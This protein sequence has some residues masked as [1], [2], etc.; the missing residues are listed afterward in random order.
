MKLKNQLLILTSG[1]V[2]LVPI[3]VL[4]C[5]TKNNKTNSKTPIDNNKE[6][7]LDETKNS[8]ENTK[9]ITNNE[10]ETSEHSDSLDNNQK[11]DSD[12]MQKPN[13]A[14]NDSQ[15]E[16]DNQAKSNSSD[17]NSIKESEK[18]SSESHEPPTV[19]PNFPPGFPFG[20]QDYSKE[21]SYP[22][23]ATK[24][25]AVEAK[26]I[27]QEIYDRTFMLGYGFE[28]EEKKEVTMDVGTTWL[29]DYYKYK[30]G[31]KYKLFFA[32]NLHV[33]SYFTNAMDEEKLK[34]FNYKTYDNTKLKS[35]FLGKSDQPKNFDDIPNNSWQSHIQ[36]NGGAVQKFDK[37][38]F[39]N[40]K[41][42]F[43]A[44][45][46]MDDDSYKDF[47][48]IIKTKYDE[49]QNS[50]KVGKEK[51]IE[52][53][54]KLD[55]P[56]F[57]PFYKDFG[58]IEV[59]IDFDKQVNQS[60][61]EEFNKL[62]AQIQKA[63][64]SLNSAI[65]KTKKNTVPNVKNQGK[66]LIDYDY[67]SAGKKIEKEGKNE[68]LLAN[69][70]NIFVAGYPN[71]NGTS[72][73]MKNLPRERNSDTINYFRSPKN[74]EAFVY[75]TND[76]QKSNISLNIY[77]NVWNRIFIDYYGVNLNLRFSSL[78]HGASGSV[79]INEFDQIVGIYSTVSENAQFGDLL[80]TSGITPLLQ[81]EDLTFEDKTFFAHNLLD[82]SGFPHQK[83]SYR[84]NLE[85]LYPNGFENE[86]KVATALFPE[87]NK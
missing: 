23:Y 35:V 10:R 78:Y 41:L 39:E 19:P 86:G 70:K 51:Y 3:S 52:I 43:A 57:I 56:E 49:Y 40:P 44:V 71:N 53:Q 12:T 82:K 66:Y 31:N 38:F 24:F 61:Q 74:K 73:W 1:L 65:E 42:V 8:D 48:D 84:S 64:E 2:P 33:L 29:L 54:K 45:D 69:A 58:V 77:T 85:V 36:D 68:S 22:E 15:S 83:T 21:N 9:P 17:D 20:P 18:D 34:E 76:I 46:F 5:T 25:T 26:D 7:K 11:N 63:I 50:N 28:D 60:K 79:A 6:S 55:K 30:T 59:T 37:E 32:T 47:N 27:Y 75:A 80:K 13:N 87:Q 67:Y 62:K 16:T 81:A 14:S 72:Y 4:S